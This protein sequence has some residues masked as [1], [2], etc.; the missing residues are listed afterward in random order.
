MHAMLCDPRDDIVPRSH[1]LLF[2]FLLDD[3]RLDV[4][5]SNFANC[6]D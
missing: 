1:A 5:T 2:L 4:W 6:R 3:A